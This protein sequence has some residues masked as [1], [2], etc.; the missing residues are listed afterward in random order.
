VAK[1][2]GAQSRDDVLRWLCRQFDLRGG[3]SFKAFLLSPYV[4]RRRAPVARPQPG[5]AGEG[6]KVSQC[7]T[8]PFDGCKAPVPDQLF[9]QCS[10]GPLG[11]AV[12]LGLVRQGGRAGDPH[13]ADL[14]IENP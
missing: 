3:F 1:C 14:V 10:D 2:T 13:D 11:N 6:G 7:E 12:A 5:G 4:I 8:Q 9:R